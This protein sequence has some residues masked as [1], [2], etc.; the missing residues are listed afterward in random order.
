MRLVEQGTISLDEPVYK[1]IDPW[2]AK[3]NP[4]VP[5]LLTLWGG[6]TTIQKVTT[7]H[8]LTM[9][10]GIQDYNDGELFSWTLKNPDKD[11]SPLQYLQTV[12]KTFALLLGP[13]DAIAERAT[14]FWA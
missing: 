5:S 6:D 2:H 9:R 13:V 3:Q 1:T 11:Y 10:S 14:C 8:L 7:R 12:N 4:P